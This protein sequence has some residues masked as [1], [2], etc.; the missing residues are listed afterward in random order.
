MNDIP[1]Y[2]YLKEI[3]EEIIKQK[4]P[5]IYSNSS[6]FN[7]ACKLFYNSIIEPYLNDIISKE[8]II[9]SCIKIKFNLIN[10]FPDIFPNINFPSFSCFKK[11]IEKI[12]KNIILEN[13]PDEE[14]NLE[15]IN[16]ESMKLYLEF[17]S[18]FML[19]YS[20]NKIIFSFDQI[21]EYIFQLFSNFFKEENL[22]NYK[23]CLPTKIE[24]PP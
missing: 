22:N 11:I 8:S 17:K 9:P 14:E 1:E 4:C 13:I 21:I 3:I 6:S 18:Y 7:A 20:Q 10:T 24:E 23:I 2:D 15:L 5:Y 16:L 12:I 19:Y